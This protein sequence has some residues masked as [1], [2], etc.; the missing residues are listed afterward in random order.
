V[1]PPLGG[2]EVP[3]VNFNLKVI[4]YKITANLWNADKGVLEP[5]P[6]AMIDKIDQAFKLWESIPNT[7]LNFQ[8][9]GLTDV[10]NLSVAQLPD[11]GSIV[12]VLDGSTLTFN[13]EGVSGLGGYSG[14]IPDDYRKGY[15]IL[16]TKAGL[17]SLKFNTLV[18]EIGHA[19]GMRHAA[20]RASTMFCGTKGWWDYEFLAF[21][22]QDRADL[23][24]LWNPALGYR[25]SGTVASNTPQYP[26]VYAVEVSNGHTY[27]ALATSQGNFSIQIAKP[28]DYRVFAKGYEPG[29]FGD[30]IHVAPTW[31]VSSQVGS[32]NP[33]QGTII[34]VTNTNQFVEGVNF[35]FI[36]VSPPFN[37]YWSSPFA[38]PYAIYDPTTGTYIPHIFSVEELVDG[39]PSLA[40]PG[41]I[42]KFRTQFAGDAVESIEAFGNNP[43]YDVI[44]YDPISH[45]ITIHVHEDATE[46]NR[47]LVARGSSGLT[48]FGD[49]GFHIM[50]TQVPGYT[51][52]KVQDQLFGSTDFSLMNTQYWMQ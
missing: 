10:S 41:Q 47:L 22:E 42:I 43:D 9:A 24:S 27:S 44:S 16:N 36:E 49:L 50:R 32:N 17:Y 38:F 8:Y 33:A 52:F 51:P 21:S 5:T 25:I 34:S 46:G 3:D 20:S 29:A 31:Y 11:D 30:I 23:I 26:L 2:G 37:F 19:L 15:V 6:Q 39:G 35:P 4:P 45:I 1:D 40:R 13:C 18:H 12:I 48:Q 7:N 28:G 14:T